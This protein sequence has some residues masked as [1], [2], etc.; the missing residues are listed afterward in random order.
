M[1]IDGTGL[2]WVLRHST[3][4]FHP[5][6]IDSVLVTLL[7]AQDESKRNSDEQGAEG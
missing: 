1:D 6:S 3:F 5:F 2:K 4:P 7:R